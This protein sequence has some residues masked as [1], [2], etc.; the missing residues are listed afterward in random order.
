MI[1]VPA[2][3]QCGHE[4]HRAAQDRRR[5]HGARGQECALAEQGHCVHRL[6]PQR[7]VSE[8][9]DE[10][11]AAETLGDVQHGVD[12]P[13]GNYVGDGPRI[14]GRERG[15]D[16]ARILLVHGHGNLQSAAAAAETVHD[17]EA[18]HVGAH[19]HG[20]APAVR[21]R[22]PHRLAFEG[23]I[24]QLELFVDQIDPGREWWWRSSTPAESGRARAGHAPMPAADSAASDGAPPVR[25]GRNKIAIPYRG[26]RL[27]VLPRCR[28]TKAMMRSSA[29]LPRSRCLIQSA[30]RGRWAASPASEVMRRRPTSCRWPRYGSR[31]G[32]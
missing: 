7:A 19:E 16:L 18:A 27:N 26:M 5:A 9:A 29:M 15:V 2:A 21:L 11:A 14:D 28:E 20:A 1:V 25:T 32:P 12:P 17:L 23:D 22:Q 3:V 13:E 4:E 24:E 10:G 6:T 30:L 31:R 8:H